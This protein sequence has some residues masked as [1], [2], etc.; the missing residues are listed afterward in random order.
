MTLQDVINEAIANAVRAGAEWHAIVR[1][2]QD[3][4][5]A[6][7]QQRQWEQ[8]PRYKQTLRHHQRQAAEAI[9]RAIL[10]LTVGQERPRQASL[11]GEPEAETARRVE[12]ADRGSSLL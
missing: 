2:R 3:S 8:D 5:E 10:R 4:A 11:F 6:G 12:E 7:R 1:C 9:G